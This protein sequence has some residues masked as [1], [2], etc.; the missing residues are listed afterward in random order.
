MRKRD[1]FLATFSTNAI[2]VIGK[3]GIGIEY[4]QFCI[5]DTLDD[6]RIG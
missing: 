1:L 3:Y 5:S 2:E 4:N 6:D